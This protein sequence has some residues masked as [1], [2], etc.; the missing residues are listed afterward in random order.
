MLTIAI[1][2]GM[3]T[4]PERDQYIVMEYLPKGSVDAI[5]EK[6]DHGLTTTDLIRM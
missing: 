5:I 4:S 2:Q 6:R 3:Y 1:T